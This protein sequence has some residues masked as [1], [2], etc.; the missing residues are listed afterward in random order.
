MTKMNPHNGN[1]TKSD[2]FSWNIFKSDTISF[3]IKKCQSI[4]MAFIIKISQI[5]NYSEHKQ[6]KWNIIRY[7]SWDIFKSGFI[8]HWSKNTKILQ[9]LL[10]LRSF[11]LIAKMSRNKYSEM[12]LN[13]ARVNLTVLFLIYDEIHN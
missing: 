12:K 6:W 5:Y 2:I 8:F 13:K 11:S 1:E 4:F 9:W 7:F 3:Y 10:Q